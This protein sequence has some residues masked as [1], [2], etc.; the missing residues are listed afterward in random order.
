M[1]ERPTIPE[2][3]LGRVVLVCN[4]AAVLALAQL[5]ES[6]VD[7]EAGLD[8]RLAK[9]KAMLSTRSPNHRVTPVY[10]MHFEVS[11]AKLRGY[12]EQYLQATSVQKAVTEAGAHA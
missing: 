3:S 1:P 12:W 11:S 7:T 9:A 4:I 5:E 8:I 6:G 2:L 10:E